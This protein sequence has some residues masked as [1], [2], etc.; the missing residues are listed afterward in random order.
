MGTNASRPS[1]DPATSWPVMPFSATFAITFPAAG[2]TI[3]RLRSPFCATSRRPVCAPAG[4]AASDTT[5]TTPIH[6]MNFNEGLPQLRNANQLDFRLPQ[7]LPASQL[8]AL[9]GLYVP[10][11]HECP[12]GSFTVNSR[13]PYS[14]SCNGRTMVAPAACARAYTASAWGTTIY[15][16]L[17]STPPNSP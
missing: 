14:I 15:A 12:S 5:A 13:L 9:H 4:A 10:T 8:C 2:S 6:E 1:G 16:L 7:K 11:L 3:A 17:V